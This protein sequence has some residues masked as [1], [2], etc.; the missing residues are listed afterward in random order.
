MT[1]C[2]RIPHGD[3]AAIVAE[4][5][6]DIQTD[7]MGRDAAADAQADCRNLIFNVRTPFPDGAPRCRRAPGRVSPSTLNAASAA[8]NPA[9]KVVNERPHVAA[10]LFQVEHHVGDALAG[11]VIG[12]LPAAPGRENRQQMPASSRSAGLALV[13]AVYSG[14]CSS[15][16]IEFSCAAFS[17]GCCARL[18]DRERIGIADGSITD[19]PFDG[20]LARR[21]HASRASR[22]CALRMM[23]S[24]ATT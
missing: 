2:P 24:D 7:A 1:P 5:G 6:F 3:D 22:L 17:D 8:A 10:A 16:Q 4:V 11:A 19:R 12:E 18:H 15:S 9:L 20:W 13:P 23:T 21:S 14:G